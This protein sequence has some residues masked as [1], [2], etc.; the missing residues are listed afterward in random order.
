[1]SDDIPPRMYRAATPAIREKMLRWIA[2]LI[3]GWPA[4]E[5]LTE[6]QKAQAEYI[7]DQFEE[8]NKE[9]PLPWE[10]FTWDIPGRKNR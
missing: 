5:Q 1:M 3:P 7:A 8:M 10:C 9:H 2:G 4:F 6:E